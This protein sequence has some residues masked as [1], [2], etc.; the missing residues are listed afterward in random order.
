MD[1]G[2]MERRGH[3]D[4]DQQMLTHRSVKGPH[5]GRDQCGPWEIQR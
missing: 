1:T 4:R 2:K 3:G 5:L